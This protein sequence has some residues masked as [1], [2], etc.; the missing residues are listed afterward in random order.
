MTSNGDVYKSLS[1]E[2]G[3]F[4]LVSVLPNDNRD[5][6][7]ECKLYEASLAANLTFVALSYVWGSVDRDPEPISLNG[8]PFLVTQN[9]KNLLRRLR[10]EYDVPSLIWVDAICINQDDAEER[11]YQVRQMR[12]IYESARFVLVCLD[13]EDHGQPYA[14]VLHLLEELGGA[15]DPVF[16]YEGK[17]RESIL[18]ILVRELSKAFPLPEVWEGVF[19]L[20]SGPWF[21]RTW[22]VQE[23]AVAKDAKMTYGT[24]IV[25]WSW[26]E[27]AITML[28]RLYDHLVPY[29][30]GDRK[31]SDGNIFLPDADKL[32]TPVQ[33]KCIMQPYHILPT[34]LISIRKQAVEKCPLETL[35]LFIETWGLEA[36]DPRDKVFALLGLLEHSA[37][38]EFNIDYSRSV[39]YTY[40]EATTKIIRQSGSLEVFL[41]AGTP[42]AR[43]LLLPSW[44]PDWRACNRQ[45]QLERLWLRASTCYPDWAAGGNL[46]RFDESEDMTRICLEGTIVAEI[47]EVFSLGKPHHIW[48][49][50]QHSAEDH[51]HSTNMESYETPPDEVEHDDIYQVFL[52][53]SSLGTIT[54]SLGDDGS[55]YST[56]NGSSVVRS[57]DDSSHAY[58]TS[59]SAK[60]FSNWMHHLLASRANR[61]ITI[62]KTEHPIGV[63]PVNTQVGDFICILFGGKTPFVLRNMGDQKHWLL[64]GACYVRGIMHGEIMKEI[65]D[66]T[67]RVNTFELH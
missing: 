8:H 11:S 35:S 26:L 4:R 64:V 40:A 22:T 18:N 34:G 31:R 27:D 56:I 3:S 47:E 43:D 12:S 63:A 54:A 32:V 62:A 55:L 23:I 25:P 57:S 52:E 14:A 19:R 16:A 49:E 5:A 2:S 38:A 53:L 37:Q 50:F 39:E 10:Q 66:G 21:S 13:V 15:L 17:E 24:S 45:S 36:T 48:D 65:E 7:I 46:T 60:T 20:L 59:K 30:L 58:I 28:E 9:L 1:A 42:R 67:R 6:L 44:S 29:R 61:Y 41:L 33:Q 51:E